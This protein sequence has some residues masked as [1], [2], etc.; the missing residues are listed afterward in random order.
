MI[1]PLIIRVLILALAFGAVML[2]AEAIGSWIRGST[3][4]GRA[5]NRRLK[6]ISAGSDRAEVLSKL[7]R[8]DD[9]TAAGNSSPFGLL[10]SI[11]AK[12]L[13][14]AGLTM[15]VETAYLVLLA[16]PVFLLII[17]VLLAAFA[18]YVVSYGLFIMCAAFSVALSWGLP[19]LVL[20][21]MAQNRRKKMEEQF[22]VALDTFVRGLRAGHPVAS[23]IDLLTTEMEDPCG[24]E[25]GIVSDEV[26][27][28]ADLRE[29]LQRMAA[30]WDMEELHMF[31]ISL[32]IQNET[33]GNLAEI[34]EKLSAIVRERASLYLKVRALS[35][36]G[37]V[38]ALILTALPIFAFVV[39]FLLSPRFYLDVAG[40]RGFLIG[41]PVL[42]VL[43]L[44][45]FITIRRMVDLKV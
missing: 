26:A 17:T 39:L 27:F 32:S 8:D 22:P 29:S 20:S 35:S 23:A 40:E 6:L 18:G 28:G 11:I 41:F 43:Y 1:S 12:N 10:R 38:T 42:I 33:G 16:G 9:F 24:G 34:L 31:V 7:R 19:L 37:R 13:H 44:V 25:F 36:E 15:P 3:V 14:A 2:A 4:S 21:R 30:R 5:I 45:G